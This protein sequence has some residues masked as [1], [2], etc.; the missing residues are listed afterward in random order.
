MYYEKHYIKNF[1]FDIWAL[2]YILHFMH[3]ADS[4]F[5]ESKMIY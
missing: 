2:L 4:A 3:L 5:K 1:Y